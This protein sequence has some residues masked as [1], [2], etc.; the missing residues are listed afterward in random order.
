MKS[1][2]VEDDY[3]TAEVMRE[4]MSAF[5]ECDVAEDGKRALD[6]FSVALVTKEVYDVI[7]LD[8]MMPE[9]DGQ[10]TLENIRRMENDYDI[11]GLDGVKIVMTTALDDFENIKKA[12]KSQCEGYIVKPIDKDKIVNKLIELKLLEEM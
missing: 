4:I 9:L 10:E 8:I 5:G 1:L 11:R 3:I 12:F 2:I 6:F 7:F